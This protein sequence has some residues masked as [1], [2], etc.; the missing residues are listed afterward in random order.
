MT[1]TNIAQVETYDTDEWPQLIKDFDLENLFNELYDNQLSEFS[2]EDYGTRFVEKV[3]NEADDEYVFLTPRLTGGEVFIVIKAGPHS[4]GDDVE[5]AVESD[6][7]LV[8]ADGDNGFVLAD[9]LREI[10]NSGDQEPV[11]IR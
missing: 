6:G 3:L 8:K 5:I 11:S 2:G 10:A 1:T 4:V 7:L 9:E